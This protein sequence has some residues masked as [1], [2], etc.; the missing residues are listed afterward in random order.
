[1]EEQPNKDNLSECQDNV[2]EIQEKKVVC[3]KKKIR[4]FETYISKILKT[5]TDDNGITVNAKQQL[6]S[7]ICLVAKY[8]GDKSRDLVVISKKKTMSIKQ[9][10]NAYWEWV[11]VLVCFS[12]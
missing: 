9:I 7:A 5:I 3:K 11:I 1:M 8:L 12:T 6:N 4:Y 10:C 2:S